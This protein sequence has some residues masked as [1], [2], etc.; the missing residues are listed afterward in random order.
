MEES[1][2]VSGFP[3]NGTCS[4][5]KLSLDVIKE[6]LLLLLQEQEIKKQGIN[7]LM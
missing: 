7:I 5:T 6:S 2:V 4:S 3:I 1:T